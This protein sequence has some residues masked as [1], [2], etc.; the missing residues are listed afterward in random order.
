MYEKEYRQ[1]VR[2]HKRVLAIADVLAP[3]PRKTSQLVEKRLRRYIERIERT[4]IKQEDSD[5]VENLKR[6]S[7]GFW[8][9]LFTC[10]DHPK[11]PRTNNEIELFFRSVKTAHRRITGL[12]S[13]NRYIIRHGENVVFACNV[14]YDSTLLKRLRNVSYDT[15]RLEKNK[16]DHRISVHKKQLQ[17]KKNP[18]SFLNQLERK[19]INGNCAS[20]SV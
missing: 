11:I 5:F 20:C 16:W 7:K 19:W 10:Y 4:L 12:R 14:V 17:F 3:S 1:V 6:Y 2:W 13:W 18:T 15:Y 8:K 9:G